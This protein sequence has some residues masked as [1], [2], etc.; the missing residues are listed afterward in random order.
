[1]ARALD[2]GGD[3]TIRKGVYVKKLLEFIA[4]ADRV[5]RLRETGRPCEY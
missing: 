5:V 4:E 1:M 2:L 3:S